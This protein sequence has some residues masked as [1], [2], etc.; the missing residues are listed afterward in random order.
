MR[1]LRSRSLAAIIALPLVAAA[2]GG[3]ADL[4]DLATTLQETAGLTE[5]QATCVAD[6][7]E[8]SGVYD[9]DTINDLSDGSVDDLEVGDM[10]D[11]EAQEARQTL[12]DGFSE[13]VRTAVL[14]C[15]VG[16]AE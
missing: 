6:E 5:E 2:C 12:L 3:S 7:I 8:A 9:D 4:D 15:G 16:Q 10:T 1:F 13:D 14:G 11:T